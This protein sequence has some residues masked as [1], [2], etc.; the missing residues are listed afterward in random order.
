MKKNVGTADRVVRVTLG[1]VL[2]SLAFFGP[3]TAWGYLGLI[4]LFTGLFGTC[5]LYSVLG[6]NTCGVTHS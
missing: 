6:F 5:A 2:L 3:H 1:V 4:P